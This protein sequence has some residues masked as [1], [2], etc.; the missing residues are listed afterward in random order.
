MLNWNITH[1]NTNYVV[2]KNLTRIKKISSNGWQAFLLSKEAITNK[3]YFQA[4]VIKTVRSGGIEFGVVRGNP[5]ALRGFLSP[6]DTVTNYNLRTQLNFIVGV[7]DVIGV[8]VNT[9]SDQVLLYR[10]KK[11]MRVG[12]LEPSALQVPM[13]AFLSLYY[14]DSELEMGNFFPFHL[15]EPMAN[16]IFY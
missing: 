14:M 6:K 12:R 4:K 11:L 2:D 13:Y 3:I 8:H 10:N 16:S 5:K 15:L 9:K 7:G 1:Y